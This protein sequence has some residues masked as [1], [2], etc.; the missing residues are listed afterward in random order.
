M[1]LTP[2]EISALNR[3]FQN[4]GWH[5]L[6]TQDASVERFEIFCEFLDKL[7]VEE[8]NLAICLTEAFVEIDISD[9][10]FHLRAAFE[11]FDDTN[12]CEKTRVFVVPLRS[13][14]DKRKGKAKSSSSLPYF[15]VSNVIPVLGK[16]QKNQ[17]EALYSEE[18]LNDYFA[19]RGPSLIIALDDFVGSGDT[20][21]KFIDEMENNYLKKEDS[22]A[23]IAIS[24][25]ESGY[26]SITERGYKMLYSVMQKRGITDSDIIGDKEKA[27]RLVD[28]I[29]KRINVSSEYQ[30]GYKQSEALIKLA[31][32][33]NNTFPMYWTTKK[34]KGVPWPAPFPR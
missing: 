7:D 3:I 17:K 15:F 21:H 25:L 5:D 6:G 34:V 27:L 14:E 24:A 23:I 33:P 20:C 1:P 8:R 19:E 22:L 18:A 11:K 32:T 16:F 2:T 29:E 26:K 28:N 4:Q 9:Y 12:I 13:P 31:R 30:R 10:V